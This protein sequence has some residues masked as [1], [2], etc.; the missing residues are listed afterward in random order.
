MR[1]KYTPSQFKSDAKRLLSIAGNRI[2]YKGNDAG[3]YRL[4][5]GDDILDIHIDVY[6]SK[7]TVIIRTDKNRHSQ[8]LR[9]QSWEQIQN[10]FNN[11]SKFL[12]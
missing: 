6:L 2:E 7:N 3:T 4:S 12:K 1:N 9:N 5:F 11:L 10:I 8:Y